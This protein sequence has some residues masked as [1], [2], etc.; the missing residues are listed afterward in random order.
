[1]R[2]GG[3]ENV[4]YIPMV[5]CKKESKCTHWW[6]FIQE[7]ALDYAKKLDSPDFRYTYH[8]FPEVEI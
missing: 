3:H 6:G 2:T 7:K 4:D 5:P 1:M 8:L